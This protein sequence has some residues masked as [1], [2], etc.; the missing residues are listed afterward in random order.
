MEKQ[1]F[2][3]KERL[4]GQRRILRP[5]ARGDVFDREGKLLIGNKAQFSAVIHLDALKNEIWEKKVLLKKLAFKM[6][7]DLSITNLSINQFLNY[8]LNQPHLQNKSVQLSGKI[9]DNKIRCKLFLGN[10]R[11]TVSEYENNTWKSELHL[12]KTINDTTFTSINFGTKISAN[13]AGLFETS[14]YLHKDNQYY[15]KQSPHLSNDDSLSKFDNFFNLGQKH[16]QK[17]PTFNTSL[18]SLNWEAR[19]AVVKN[20]LDQ[21]NLLLGKNVKLDFAKLKI[22]WNKR[23]VLPMELVSNLNSLEYALLI[24]GLPPKSPV[25]IQSSSIRHYPQKSLASHVLGY[26][27]SGYESNGQNLSGS[28]LSTFEIKGK[29]GK[30]GIEKFFDTLLRGKDGGDIWRIS[31]IGLRFEQIEKN[32]SKKGTSIQLSIDIDLQKTAENSLKEMSKRVT[33]HRILPDKN[34]KQTIEKRTLKELIN[35]NENDLR[36]E[37]LLSAFKDAPFPLNGKEASTVAGFNGTENDAKNLL[38]ILYSKG[39]LDKDINTDPRY[40]I[41]PPPAP[42]GAAVLLDIKTSEIL[43]LASIPNYNLEDLSPRISQTTYDQIERQEAWLP[44]AWHPGYSPA[45]PFKLI[46][47]VAALKAKV[48]EPEEIFICDG[49]Y[50]GMICHC[51]P[52]RHGEM[53]LRK[54]EAQSCNVYFFQLAERLGQNRLID[55]AKT[56]GMNVTP[57]IELPRLRNSPNVP[58][59]EWK[60]KNVGEKW[61]LED[62]FNMAIGQGGLRQSPLQMACFAAAL[63]NRQKIFKPTLVRNKLSTSPQTPI[64]LTDKDYTAIVDGM[65]DAT[66][67][68]TARRCKIEGIAI[69]GKTGT[70]QWRNHNMK[71]SLA[72]FIGFAPAKN[73]QVAI[74]VLVEGVI[75]QDHIQGGLT[76]TPVARD[77]LQAY[78]NKQKQNRTEFN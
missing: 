7:D 55:E 42:P 23:L 30:A 38:R 77:I 43:A 52:G 73:P 27:G 72:W 66:V 4:Q 17:K 62:T 64:G 13:V 39:V 56:F 69:A 58:D 16:E 34:W 44:R 32:L 47:A 35:T 75:P 78:F 6:R 9:E 21:I 26:V 19:Y 31:P 54:A 45:S 36:P 22:H 11:L 8:C 68:G 76:A 12:T 65:L 53:D 2:D 5:G 61:A 49:I 10:T 28:D 33:A 59:P 74:A 67:R 37:L 40:F 51:Y 29:K 71:L 15:A 50:K 70:A 57:K 18:F 14:F 48:V 41:A 46:T 63:A 60:K 20:Y 25:Q 3:E 24:E 1:E